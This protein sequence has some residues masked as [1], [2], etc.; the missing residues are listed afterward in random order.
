M[1]IGVAEGEGG[2]QDGQDPAVLAWQQAEIAYLE[3]LLALAQTQPRS[4]RVVTVDLVI[5]ERAVDRELRLR[6]GR[7]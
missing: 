5:E 7:G 2:E 1:V 6:H 3:Q 4:N